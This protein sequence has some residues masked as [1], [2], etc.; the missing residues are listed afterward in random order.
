MSDTIKGIIKG[1]IGVAFLIASALAFSYVVFTKDT[2][3]WAA[4]GLLAASVVV[5]LS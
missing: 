5:L 4:A 2:I 1:I 3:N